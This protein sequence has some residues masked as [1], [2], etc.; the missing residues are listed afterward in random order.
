MTAIQAPNSKLNYGWDGEEQ[1][2]N[3]Q[4]DENWKIIDA[5]LNSV[6]VLGA[7][8]A[9]PVS[10]ITGDK[11]L[12]TGTAT[13]DFAG[14]ENCIARYNMSSWEMLTLTKGWQL[15]DMSNGQRYIHDGYGWVLRSSLL[16]QYADDV[17]AG[18]DG[19]LIGQEYI[20][21][22]NGALTIKLV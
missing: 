16:G 4:L 3:L 15:L 19:V 5:L 21:S 11:Y 8:D 7:I 20:N 18:T 22:S 9:P 17:A 14:Y 6:T 1:G 12:I 2:I 13:G 10:P